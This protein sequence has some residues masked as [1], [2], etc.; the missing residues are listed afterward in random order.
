MYKGR[1]IGKEEKM[2]N[3]KNRTNKKTKF[4]AILQLLSF[5]Y[6]VISIMFYIALWICYQ[7]YM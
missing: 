5:V 7:E 4:D 6:V 1:R 2:S 3:K